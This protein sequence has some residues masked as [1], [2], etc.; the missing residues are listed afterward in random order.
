VQRGRISRLAAIGKALAC[1]LNPL[2]MKR[3]SL[4]M[5]HNIEVDG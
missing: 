4:S 2:Q 1:F 3:M 5:H